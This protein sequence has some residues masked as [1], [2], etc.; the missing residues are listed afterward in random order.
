MFRIRGLFVE[1]SA[2]RWLYTGSGVMGDFIEVTRQDGA[3]PL[4]YD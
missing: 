2:L 4:N 1:F 3:A